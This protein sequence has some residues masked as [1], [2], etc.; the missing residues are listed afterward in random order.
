MSYDFPCKL[1]VALQLAAKA[2]TMTLVTGMFMRVY[3]SISTLMNGG[4]GRG[5]DGLA[6][7]VLDRLALPAMGAA[8][9]KDDDCAKERADEGGSERPE[10]GG[11]IS[12][13][14]VGILQIGLEH[15]EPG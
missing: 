10:T 1:R 13:D 9:E 14:L 15:P 8:S 6:S 12:A 5:D 2:A 3:M 4:G 11:K 7:V